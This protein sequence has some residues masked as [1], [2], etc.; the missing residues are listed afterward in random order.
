MGDTKRESV[1][2]L[3]VERFPDFDWRWDSDRQDLWYG[4]YRNLLA[5]VEKNRKI[6][7]FMSI[8]RERREA[9]LD[10]IVDPHDARREEVRRRWEAFEEETRRINEERS[11]SGNKIALLIL[12]AIFSA[13]ATAGFYSWGL[14]Q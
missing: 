7:E 8:S 4:N 9:F 2:T 1:L 11:R 13:L 12:A 3:A 6:E 14:L 5:W 10:T